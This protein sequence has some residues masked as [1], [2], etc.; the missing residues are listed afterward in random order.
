MSEL[1]DRTWLLRPVPLIGVQGAQRFHD[2]LVPCLEATSKRYMALRFIS[3]PE[4]HK[5]PPMKGPEAHRATDESG[6]SG[7]LKT[8]WMDKWCFRL[9]A[10]VLV[11]VDLADI[12]RRNRPAT[13]RE[14]SVAL[15]VEAVRRSFQGRD[16]KMALLLV[17]DE[18]GAFV[19]DDFVQGIR[20]RVQIENRYIKVL[21]AS[22]LSSTSSALVQLEKS[23]Q[24]LAEAF[25]KQMC[26]RLRK[27]LSA[28]ATPS[29]MGLQG[30]GTSDS[31]RSAVTLAWEARKHFQLGYAYEFRSEAEKAGLNYRQCFAAV[32]RMTSVVGR[33]IAAAAKA[34]TKGAGGQAY[35]RARLCECRELS[36]LVTLRLCRTYLVD[37]RV[38]VAVQ[39]FDAHIRLFR[40]VAP[41][42]STPALHRI[43]H[44]ASAIP[45]GDVT[46]AAPGGATGGTD[47]E[48]R[49]VLVAFAAY[50]GRLSR[51]C[52]G[53]CLPLRPPPPPR[54]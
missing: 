19:A 8:R 9:P 23:A 50:C 52:V 5:Y 31:A 22:D 43:A 27:R 25:Y 41:L 32:G 39:Q 17:H 37:R 1:I 21:Y 33:A 7:L 2:E 51:E 48:M 42:G 26:K 49:S 12:F 38:E 16:V 30:G 53:R 45:G 14:N 40:S 3:L 4:G 13:T 54:A 36:S 46:L 44:A 18:P 29:R 10:V 35:L 28:L 11:V 47:A 15:Q 20:K 24:T 34:R 6:P